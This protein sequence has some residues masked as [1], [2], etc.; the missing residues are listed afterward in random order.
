MVLTQG[1]LPCPSCAN[2]NR[3]VCGQSIRTGETKTFYNICLMQI[4]DCGYSEPREF[5]FHQQI[6][7]Y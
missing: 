2:T 6:L 5:D 4:E 1:L 7:I 3:P